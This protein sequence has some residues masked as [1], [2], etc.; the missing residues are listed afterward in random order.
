MAKVLNRVGQVHGTFK[1]IGELGGNRV[2]VECTECG[3]LDTVIKQRCVDK[4]ITCKN[5]GLNKNIVNRVGETYN[6]LLIIKELGKSKV[7]CECIQCGEIDTY[8]KTKL[9]AKKIAC[10]HCEFDIP[11]TKK[12][13]KTK[14]VVIS[15][16]IKDRI[17]VG[18]VE[19]EILGEKYYRCKCKICRKEMVL[20]LKEM[21]NHR[22]PNHQ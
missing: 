4:Q 11:T 17:K 18:I 10:R 13:K 5:C 8:D 21:K 7:S 19:Y 15:Q 14:K 16:D 6:N 20:S 2:Q 22:C 12:A 9:V 1:I 3:Y